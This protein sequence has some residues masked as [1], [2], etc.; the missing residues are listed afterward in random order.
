MGLL[1][2]GTGLSLLTPAW[3]ATVASP[4]ALERTQC[5]T[6]ESLFWTQDTCHLIV[7][8]LFGGVH[9]TWGLTGLH[10]SG[11]SVRRRGWIGRKLEVIC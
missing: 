10:C 4:A 1:F 5:W 2:R 9:R 3:A 11:C 8:E 6:M 7:K